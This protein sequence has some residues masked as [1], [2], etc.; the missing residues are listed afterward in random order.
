MDYWRDV[1]TIEV[2]ELDMR[3]KMFWLVSVLWLLL[4]ANASAFYDPG[5]QRWINRDPSEEEGGFNLYVPNDN[6]PTDGIDPDGLEGTNDSCFDANDDGARN[7]NRG[8][9]RE[10]NDPDKHTGAQ[11]HGGKRSKPNMAGTPP[12]AAEREAINAQKIKEG[13]IPDPNAP[14][15]KKGPKKKSSGIIPAGMDVYR[16]WEE[17]QNAKRMHDEL[18]KRLPPLRRMPPWPPPS[19]TF[20]NTGA[21]CDR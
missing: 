3:A 7:R 8:G 14:M 20:P 2:M 12:T 10:G 15:R 6:D 18:Q 1:E 21:P 17:Y 5:L 16:A 19:I 11:S 4:V 13:K 9:H